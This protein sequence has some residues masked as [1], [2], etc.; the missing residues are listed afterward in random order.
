MAFDSNVKT[1]ST[2]CISQIPKLQTTARELLEA[3]EAAEQRERADNSTTNYDQVKARSKTK[4]AINKTSFSAN[5][6]LNKTKEARSRSSLEFGKNI[7][8]QETSVANFLKRI[9]SKIQH[10]ILHKIKLSS[11][12]SGQ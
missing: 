1:L 8:N 3:M 7:N 6:I 10:K 2:G 12:N 4:N 9:Y 5:N 11:C